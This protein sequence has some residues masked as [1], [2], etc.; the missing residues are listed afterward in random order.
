MRWG[1]GTGG[2]GLWLALA[3]LPVFAPQAVQPAASSS[4]FVYGKR[5]S[6]GTVYEI[7]AYDQSLERASQALDAAFS[8]IADLDRIM[9]NYDAQSD[10]SRMERSAHFR[11]VR[12]A[13]DLYR[14]I[15]DSLLYSRLSGRQI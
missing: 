14:V 9:S 1:K 15:Q 2:A 5:Y 6:M 4:R 3:A 8:K 13:P 7:V 12:V 11:A 10:L